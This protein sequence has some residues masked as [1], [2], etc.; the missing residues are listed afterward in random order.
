MRPGFFIV[1]CFFKPCTTYTN[2]LI[3]SNLREIYALK[4]ARML[5]L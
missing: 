3:V 1:R 2:A 4:W 5:L